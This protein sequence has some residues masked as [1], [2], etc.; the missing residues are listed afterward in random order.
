LKPTREDLPW[1]EEE[2][3]NMIESLDSGVL[4]FPDWALNEESIHWRRMERRQQRFQILVSAYF[5][6]VVVMLLF[7]FQR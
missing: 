2:I 7:L 6:A 1:F 5:L 3:E 4:A